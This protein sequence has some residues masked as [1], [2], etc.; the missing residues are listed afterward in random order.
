MLTHPDKETQFLVE[1]L[2]SQRDQAVA[3]A[4]ALFRELKKAE[5]KITELEKLYAT[6]KGHEQQDASIQ[7]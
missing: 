2:E 1:V 6:E 3:Q 4:A 5:Q 7:H